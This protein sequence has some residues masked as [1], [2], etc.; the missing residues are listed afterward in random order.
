MESDL[1]GRTLVDRSQLR[2]L[3]SVSTT[4]LVVFA[5]KSAAEV[6]VP[7][8]FATFLVGVF[9]PVYRWLAARIPR[10]AA[11][12]LTAL[13]VLVVVAA[14]VT[15]L[16]AMGDQVALHVPKLRQE[17][18]P[19]IEPL[20]S[21]F[22]G[23]SSG[24]AQPAQ[25][26]ASGVMGFGSGAVLVFAFLIL[27]LLDAKPLADKIPDRERWAGVARRVAR[28][29]RRWFL[30]RTFVGLLNAVAI[31]LATAALGLEMPFVWAFSTFLLNYIHTV[32]SIA[33]TVPPVAF[34]FAAGGPG[35][36]AVA[37]VVIG[38]LQAGMG[39]VLDPLLSG[40][41]LQLAPVVI[42]LAVV[43]FGWMWGV[44]GAFLGV[45]ITVAATLICREFE[46]TAWI[47]RLLAA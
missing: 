24:V 20:L 34:A 14:F 22:G 12:G 2:I 15:G 23:G 9:W 41:Y 4:V 33:A 17:L 28:D 1:G 38:G 31:G 47:S 43:F 32:G 37:F 27:G 11:V 45:P 5:L 30:V 7:L 26:L 8:V 6:F 16:V 35:A 13:S 40:R 18:E 19:R 44:P 3:A 10:A 25:R 21:R 29:F 42:L 39:A 46:R 36:G